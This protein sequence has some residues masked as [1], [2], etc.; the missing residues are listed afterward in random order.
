MNYCPCC[1]GILLQHIRASGMTW[2]CRHCWQDMPVYHYVNS[3]SLAQM[4]VE[5]SLQE[6]KSYKNNSIYVS[7]KTTI[8]R[9]IG[10]QDISA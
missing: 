9:W 4:V 1:S 10:L 8:T 3:S 6:S 2:F 5:E 7:K